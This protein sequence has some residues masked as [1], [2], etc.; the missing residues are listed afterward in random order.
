MYI[1]TGKRISIVS[2]G[3]GIPESVLSKIRTRECQFRGNQFRRLANAIG[4]SPQSAY[5][6]NLIERGTIRNFIPPVF[7][8][9]R[10]DAPANLQGESLDVEELWPPRPRLRPLQTRRLQMQLPIL[11]PTLQFYTL[12]YTSRYNGVLC[13]N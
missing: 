12:F 13:I 1:H 8:P 6:F 3:A 2:R 10:E 9:V 11:V 4:V 7:P 5:R